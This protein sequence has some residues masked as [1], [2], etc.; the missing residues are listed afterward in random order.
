MDLIGIPVRVV[1]GK[2]AEEG[3]IEYKERAKSEVIELAIED[4]LSKF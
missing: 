3:I 1:V 2:K 4:L